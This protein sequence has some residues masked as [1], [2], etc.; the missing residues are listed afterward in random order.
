[1][2][3][4]GKVIENEKKIYHNTDR[5][6][7]HYYNYL[8]LGRNLCFGRGEI[9][10]RNGIIM[11]RQIISVCATTLICTVFMIPAEARNL[12]NDTYCVCK[13]DLFIDYWN[14][15]VKR[16]VTN[17]NDDGT[18]IAKDLADWLE[19]EQDLYAVTTAGEVDGYQI[20][21]YEY[22]YPYLNDRYS[23]TDDTS[24]VE[25]EGIVQEGDIIRKTDEIAEEVAEV[26]GLSFYTRVLLMPDFD[27]SNSIKDALLGNN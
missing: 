16:I 15:N 8:V 27:D 5:I 10:G 26:T 22:L 9:K 14:Y 20:K 6:I 13:H 17:L 4:K 1:M 21:F 19:E 23:A 25:F 2:V 7:M 11:H 3:K 24:Y 12:G 18:F